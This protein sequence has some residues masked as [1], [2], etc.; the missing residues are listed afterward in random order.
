MV[1]INMQV[2]SMGPISEIDMVSAR[3]TAPKLLLLSLSYQESV[4]RHEIYDAALPLAC[5]D[6]QK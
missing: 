3:E 6:T 1:E 2:R 5:F 4:G